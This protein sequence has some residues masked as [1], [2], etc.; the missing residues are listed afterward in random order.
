M[1]DKN[2]SEIAQAEYRLFTEAYAKFVGLAVRSVRG[3]LGLNQIEFS[4]KCRIST[5]TLY[6]IESGIQSGDITPLF[7]IAGYLKKLGIEISLRQERMLISFPTDL[8]GGEYQDILYGNDIDD[9][10]K[11][12]DI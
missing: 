7:K 12:Q 10:F 6:K 11:A 3:T 5:R 1:T 8:Y 9:I 2:V 4:A